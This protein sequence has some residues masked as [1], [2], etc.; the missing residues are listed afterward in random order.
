ML[1]ICTQTKVQGGR[2]LAVA[3][4]AAGDDRVPNLQLAEGVG[5]IGVDGPSLADARGGRPL[6]VTVTA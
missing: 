5:G 2:Q 1:E 4:D 3:M 6:A